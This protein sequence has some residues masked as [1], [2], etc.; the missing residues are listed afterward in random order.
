MN[1]GEIRAQLLSDAEKAID[2]VLAERP[3]SARITLRDI[4]RLAVQAGAELS[5]GVQ[6]ALG[7]E[8][9]Q[10]QSGQIFYLDSSVWQFPDYENADTFVERLVREGFLVRELV[11]NAALQGQLNELSLRSIQRRFVNSTGM[12]HRAVYQTERAR[13]ATILLKQGASI[14]GTVQAADYADQPHLTRSLKQLIGQTPAQIIDKNTSQ[15]L[16]YL[17]KTD[18]LAV[19]A[20]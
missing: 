3:A 11:V 10:C 16:S 20:P 17:F 19:N 4:E 5:A 18:A 8:G 1:E 2:K 7:A 12:T 9:S 6:Q 13:Y 14:L 15:Q